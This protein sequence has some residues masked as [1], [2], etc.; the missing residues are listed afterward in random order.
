MLLITYYKRQHKYKCFKP[1]VKIL[2]EILDSYSYT[3]QNMEWNC[4][5]AIISC[6]SCSLWHML[7]YLNDF[8]IANEWM[9]KKYIAPVKAYKN[10]LNLPRLAENSN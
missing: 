6:N 2:D 1:Y 8:R 4:S 3:L 5:F 7:L 10:V 9:K